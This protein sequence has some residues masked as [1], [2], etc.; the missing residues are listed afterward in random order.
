MEYEKIVTK[1]AEIGVRIRKEREASALR[2]EDLAVKVG[3]VPESRGTIANWEKGK[4]LP[5]LEDMIKLCIIFDCEVG[6]LLCEQNCK[7]REVTD[8]QAVSGLSENAIQK[9]IRLKTYI[10]GY[11]CPLNPMIEH[12]GLIDLL[13]AI[14]N[15][16]W[17]FNQERYS[18]ENEPPEVIEA[19]ATTFNCEPSMLKD[20]IKVS[21]QSLIESAVMGIVNDIGNTNCKK[22]TL[23]QRSVV[24]PDYGVA[25]QGAET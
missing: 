7:T 13:E 24:L 8:I 16:V 25:T 18:V 21:S 3:Y 22:S 5:S 14:R 4:Y 6:Y 2:Q 1:K 9:L 19:F 17:S 12:D 20:Y 23:P 11:N 10:R 15:H